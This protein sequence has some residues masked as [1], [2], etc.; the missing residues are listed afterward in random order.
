MGTHTCVLLLMLKRN[1]ALL[2]CS[3]EMTAPMNHT[4]HPEPE[5]TG[6]AVTSHH[7]HPVWKGKEQQQPF[8]FLVH[9]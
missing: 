4:V 8:K 7:Q 5:G 6:P 3:E 1:T 9:K 2:I